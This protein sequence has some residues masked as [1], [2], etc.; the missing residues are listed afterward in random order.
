MSG[1]PQKR[2]SVFYE[3]THFLQGDRP[4]LLT[5]DEARR[6]A[7]NIAKLPEQEAADATALMCAGAK[8][9]RFSSN[10]GQIASPAKTGL[11]RCSKASSFDYLV[12]GGEE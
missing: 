2:K 6:I 1:F 10:S 9:F 3:Y 8:H 4:K 7:R 12:G 11:M 5:K